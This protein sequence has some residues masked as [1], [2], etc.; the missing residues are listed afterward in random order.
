M[1]GLWG[2]LMSILLL[3][4]GIESTCLA[5]ALRPRICLTI[6]Y[7]QVVAKSEISASK[8]ICAALRLSHMAVKIDLRKFATGIMAGKQQ[9]FPGGVPEWWPFRNQILISIA[10]IV[11]F[12]KSDAEIIIGTVKS[13]RRHKDGRRKFLATMD[14]LLQYQEG[15]I[16]LRAPASQMSSEELLDW[17]KPPL[18]LLGLTFSCH[19]SIYSCG[20]CRGCWK[21]ESCVTYAILRS[22]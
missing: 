6:D 17:A 4:G 12:K 11:S 2:T 10:A 15:S 5:Y 22:K 9:S 8:N 21:N 7:G 19:R 18:S 14:K 13:D 20:Q 1:D 16:R 3:S